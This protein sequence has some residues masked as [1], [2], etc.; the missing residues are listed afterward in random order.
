M[1][2]H[3]GDSDK[4]RVISHQPGVVL[5]VG[6][7]AFKIVGSGSGTKVLRRR[8]NAPEDREWDEIGYEGVPDPV[9]FAYNLRAS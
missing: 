7:Y 4:S 1:D 5:T 2:K 9:K 6:F 8:A 3:L